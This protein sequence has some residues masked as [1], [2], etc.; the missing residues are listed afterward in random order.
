MRSS[1]RRSGWFE[2]GFGSGQ[3]GSGGNAS[4]EVRLWANGATSHMGNN[5]RWSREGGIM[6]EI[7]EE[8][9]YRNKEGNPVMFDLVCWIWPAVNPI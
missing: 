5:N 8:N 3:A 9:V 2:S 4:S 6:G 7:M 1:C